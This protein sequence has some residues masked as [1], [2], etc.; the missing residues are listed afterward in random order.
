MTSAIDRTQIVKAIVDSALTV[1]PDAQGI[2]PDTH[3]LGAQ[4]VLDSV[5]FVTFLIVL[6][7]NLQSAVDLSSSLIEQA[8][9]EESNPFL[10]V[11]SL[12]AHI[13]QLLSVRS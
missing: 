5:G 8:D 11:T 6:E 10:T 7:Q 3:L 13:E 1:V 4:A 2:G 9:R 12:A